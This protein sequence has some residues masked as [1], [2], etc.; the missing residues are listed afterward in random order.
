LLWMCLMEDKQSTLKD[1]NVVMRM[2]ALWWSAAGVTRKVWKGM[3]ADWNKWSKPLSNC[4][5]FT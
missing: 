3:R 2:C 1:A 4:I 5:Y